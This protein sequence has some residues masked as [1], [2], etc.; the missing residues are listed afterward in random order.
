MVAIKLANLL[1]KRCAMCARPWDLIT[2]KSHQE[3]SVPASDWV[4]AHAS[5]IKAGGRVL[6]YAC[7][8]GR[9]TVWLAKQGFQVMAIDRDLA[10][11]Q[12]I[13][14]NHPDLAIQTEAIDLETDVWPLEHS[15]HLGQFDAVIV[16]NYLHRPSLQKLTNLLNSEGVLIYETFAIGNEAF[17]KPS[18]PDFLL[19][20]NELLGFA[21]NMRILAYEDLTVTKPKPACVQRVCAVP[22]QSKT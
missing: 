8:S 12:Q 22:L 16:T 3:L 14:S 11:L 19:T 2:V 13:K 5:K 20:P 10:S 1:K 17:G 9:H 6:D 4:Q 15:S 21:S 18:N 7:G